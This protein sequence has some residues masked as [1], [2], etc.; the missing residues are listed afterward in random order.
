VF[1]NCKAK[2]ATTGKNMRMFIPFYGISFAIT[3]SG[4]IKAVAAGNPKGS[5]QSLHRT[6]RQTKLKL[7]E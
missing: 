5:C 6:G 1:P 4:W 7:D 2:A 3:T